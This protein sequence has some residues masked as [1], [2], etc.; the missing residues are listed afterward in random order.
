MITPSKTGRKNKPAQTDAATL[1]LLPQLEKLLCRPG[2]KA[3]KHSSELLWNIIPDFLTVSRRDGRLWRKRILL[4]AQFAQMVNAGLPVDELVDVI[5][6]KPEIRTG[7]ARRL[8]FV[9][10]LIPKFQQSTG[11]KRR[12]LIKSFIPVA[13]QGN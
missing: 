10:S 8:K 4:L 7:F 13:P 3:K 9:A 11:S 6:L 12:D 1:A 5:N 2:G